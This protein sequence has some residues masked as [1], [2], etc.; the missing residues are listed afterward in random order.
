MN[1]LILFKVIW[2][3]NLLEIQRMS[4]VNPFIASSVIPYS[5]LLYMYDILCFMTLMFLII[6]HTTNK[7]YSD[8]EEALFIVSFYPWLSSMILMKPMWAKRLPS[9]TLFKPIVSGIINKW[10]LW[11]T[12]FVYIH[13]SI[14]PTSLLLHI[15][16]N[17]LASL[18]LGNMLVIWPRGG[19]TFS[20]SS[21]AYS[22]CSYFQLNYYTHSIDLTEQKQMRV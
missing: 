22:M 18:E 8:H 17:L 2:S 14:Y 12:Y 7:S 5:L 1:S 3:D 20:I 11:N 6:F 16:A 13:T 19:S 21:P 9:C 10:L 4:N 15:C